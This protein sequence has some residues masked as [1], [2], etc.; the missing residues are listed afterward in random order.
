MLAALVQVHRHPAPEAARW[1]S[2]VLTPQAFLRR[3]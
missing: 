1:Q 2:P 3:L